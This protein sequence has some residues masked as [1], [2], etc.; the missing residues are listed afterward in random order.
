MNIKKLI[1]FAVTILWSG[2]YVNAQQEVFTNGEGTHPCYRI[3]AITKAKNGDIVAFAEG[4]RTMHDHAHN[5]L[6][7]RR[8]A[9]S[10]ITWNN[11]QV[12]LENENVMV[13]PSPVTLKN[14]DIIVFIEEF[15]NGYHARAGAHM[16]LLSEGFGEGS[17]KLWMLRSHDHGKTWVEPMNLTKI[18]RGAEGKMLTSGSP[19]ASIQLKY[20]KNKGRILVPLYC[21]TWKGGNRYNYSSVLISDNNGNTWRRSSNVKNM[22][23]LDQV[24]GTK[25]GSCNEFHIAQLSD[26]KVVINARGNSGARY[27]SVSSDGGETWTKYA[28]I[29][30]GRTNNNALVALPVNQKNN[31]LVYTQSGDLKHRRHGELYTSTD[32]IE[33]KKIKDLTPEASEFGY[34]A[35]TV[36]ENG[37]V[38]LLYESFEKDNKCIRFVEIEK[39]IILK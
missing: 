34:S 19:A 5:D 1:I 32:G 3:P 20:R 37:N 29:M 31:I 38:G 2:F 35:L 39:E 16:K 21:T 4:R 11:Y 10:G 15:P 27:F 28:E 26:G 33:Y 22:L 8:S 14:G 36:L 30:S 6:V 24:V 7:V 12:I 17:Q 9:D 18:S 13:N 23:P 25:G